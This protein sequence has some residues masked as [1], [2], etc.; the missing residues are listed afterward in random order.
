MNAPVN[1]PARIRWTPEDYLQR[2]TDLDRQC[3]DYILVRLENG[4]TLTA[5][6]EEN[7][8]MPLPGTFL[9]W[10]REDS[11]IAERYQQAVADGTDVRFQEMLDTAAST[12]S[13]AS[14][15]FQALKHY[16]ERQMPDR[17]GPRSTVKQIN[18]PP[19]GEGPG[20][21]GGVYAADAAAVR[22]QLEDVASRRETARRAAEEEPKGDAP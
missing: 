5:V 18:K 15:E 22:K 17:Y 4:E 13:T 8:D 1:P 10:T 21:T 2:P 9:R 20:D 19:E 7:R 11:G 14:L 16:T 6:C 3:V 12:R